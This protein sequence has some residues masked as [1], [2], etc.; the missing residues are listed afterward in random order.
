MNIQDRVILALGLALCAMGFL[1]FKLLCGLYFDALFAGIVL[2][3]ALGY[4]VV[5]VAAS[6]LPQASNRRRLG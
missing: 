6:Q 1:M 2:A 3:F 4:V 5:Y